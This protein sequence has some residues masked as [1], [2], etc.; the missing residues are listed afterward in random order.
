MSSCHVQTDPL[1]ESASYIYKFV[2]QS[3]L[4]ECVVLV[5]LIAGTAPAIRF[6]IISPYSL[7]LYFSFVM[8]LIKPV[9]TK[10]LRLPPDI[11]F[12]AV[13]V[14]FTKLLTKV[15]LSV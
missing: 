9:C 6:F 4:I 11:P 10:L 12:I 13:M 8:E 14:R 15:L 3:S 5:F 1:A 2:S 7:M